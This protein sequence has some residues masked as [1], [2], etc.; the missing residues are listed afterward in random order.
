M[1]CD[2]NNTKYRG[3]GNKRVGGCHAATALSWC[4]GN[5]G[6]VS[7]DQPPVSCDH[8][9]DE[10]ADTRDLSPGEAM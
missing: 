4:E 3:G 5:V 10:E 7:T 2:I 8:A 1:S 6:S 9:D